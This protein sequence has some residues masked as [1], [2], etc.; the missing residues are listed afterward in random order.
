MD[1]NF[2]LKKSEKGQKFEQPKNMQIVI[3]PYEN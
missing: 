3:D 1:S 2:I